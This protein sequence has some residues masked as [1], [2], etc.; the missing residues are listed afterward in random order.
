MEAFWALFWNVVS[1]LTAIVG[2]LAGYYALDNARLV[3]PVI[4]TIAASSFLYVA[5]ADLMP[6]L[7]RETASIGWH[8]VLLIAGIA[9]VV[10]GSA[11]SH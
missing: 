8:T 7:K 6:R 3:I 10:F 2:G 5:I 1:S 11:H 9:V 4:I